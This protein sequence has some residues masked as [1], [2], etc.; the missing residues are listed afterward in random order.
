MSAI[1]CARRSRRPGPFSTGSFAL[2]A[3]LTCTSGDVKVPAEE[4]GPLCLHLEPS[5]GQV[6]LGEPV[7]LIV[8]LENCSDRPLEVPR[9]LAAEYGF[10]TVFARLPGADKETTYSPPVIREGRRASSV[11]LAPGEFLLEDVPI[12]FASSGWFLDT[13][14]EYRFRAQ[15]SVEKDSVTS[16]TT[17]LKVVA[18]SST[19]DRS[20]ADLFLSTAAGKTFYLGPGKD[21][22]ASGDLRRVAERHG[23]TSWGAFA[24]LALA[25]SGNGSDRS[26]VELLTEVPDAA[27]AAAAARPLASG[28]GPGATE[29]VSSR[30]LSTAPTPLVRRWVEQKLRGD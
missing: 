14:G 30:L 29:A 23:D 27:I 15:Y 5:R 4:V 8:G 20:A 16:N 13:A 26:Y 7:L 9:L 17:H 24:A 12:Y 10:L 25:S 28:A 6:L 2:L 11:T 22:D 21:T 19:S 3:V 18:P 1:A